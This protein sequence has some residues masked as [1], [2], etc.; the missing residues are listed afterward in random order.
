MSVNECVR[1]FALTL[2]AFGET[3]CEIERINHGKV[4]RRETTKNHGGRRK[5][6]NSKSSKFSGE[7][8]GG[9]GFDSRYWLG[10]TNWE[11]EWEWEWEWGQPH[12]EQRNAAR[13][14]E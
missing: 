9:S 1:K 2:R 13:S 6:R 4:E 12:R 11:W 10:A 3:A 7:R 8:L 14:R 5:E